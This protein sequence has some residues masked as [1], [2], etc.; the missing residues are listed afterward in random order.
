[1]DWW[2]EVG[3]FFGEAG[4]LIG[5]VSALILLVIFVIRTV[6]MAVVDGSF[7]PRTHVDDLLHQAD[8]RAQAAERERERWEDACHKREQEAAELRSQ[9]GELVGSMQLVVD[10]VEALRRMAKERPEDDEAS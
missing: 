4:P 2:G 3:K 8:E 5:G 7:V 1:M 10:G 9:L 6:V